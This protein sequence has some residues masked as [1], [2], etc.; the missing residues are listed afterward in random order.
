MFR[1]RT[2]DE[3]VEKKHC[4]MDNLRKAQVSINMPEN[5]SVEFLLV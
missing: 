1:V 4:R 2:I 5:P 3:L